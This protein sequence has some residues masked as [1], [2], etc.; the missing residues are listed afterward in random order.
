MRDVVAEEQPKIETGFLCEIELGYGRLLQNQGS[1]EI[2]YLIHG[3]CR[4]S[5]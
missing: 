5:C 1:G 2:I 4:D 3:I